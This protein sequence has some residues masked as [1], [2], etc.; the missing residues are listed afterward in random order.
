MEQPLHYWVPSIATSGLA[1]YGGERVPGWKGDVFVGGLAGGHLAR[2]SF[3][4]TERV[5]VEKLL[6]ELGQRIRDVRNGPDG[7]LYV[8]VDA[9]NAP[10]LRL[11]PAIA[12]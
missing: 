2:V 3:R 1:I 4:G 11:E 5:G 8:L 9:S 12:G 6:T 7:Y 10:V